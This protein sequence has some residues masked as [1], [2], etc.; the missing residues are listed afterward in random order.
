MKWTVTLLGQ[1]P[2][3]NHMYELTRVDRT[4]RRGEI[5]LDDLGRPRKYK[6]LV[7]NAKVAKYQDDVVLQVKV[8][9][10]SHWQ[11]EGFVRLTYRYFLVH[12]ID[13]DN[14][15]KAISDA[16]QI[17]IGVDDR[18]FLHCDESKVHG[19]PLS[20]ARVEIDIEG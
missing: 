12:D 15:K 7:K 2:S 1:P 9:K 18:M 8:A 4:N 6:R 19:C 5:R 17:A 3:I 10:P 20:E 13:C 14:V 16:I 11:P